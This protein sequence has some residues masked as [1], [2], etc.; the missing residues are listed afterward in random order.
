MNG[1]ALYLNF[2]V[3]AVAVTSD[4]KQVISASDDKT[5][6]VWSIKTGA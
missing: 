4:S 2:S 3:N 1:E 6:K 5:I